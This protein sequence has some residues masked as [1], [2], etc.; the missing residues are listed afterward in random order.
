MCVCVCVCVCVSSLIPKPP[1]TFHL[2]FGFESEYIGLVDF[3]SSSLHQVDMI[4][5]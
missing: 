3:V 1:K 5:M 2:G 4:V